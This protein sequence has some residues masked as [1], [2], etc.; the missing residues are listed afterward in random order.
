MTALRLNL[1][2]G[3]YVMGRLA[4][5][6]VLQNPAPFASVAGFTFSEPTMGEVVDLMPR[7]RLRDYESFW[8]DMMCGKP[9]ALTRVRNLIALDDA[10]RTFC[11]AK[12]R[13][14][15]AAREAEQE[16]GA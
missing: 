9:G 13:E 3:K 2:S 12:Y 5:Y 4:T 16:D 6:R 7:I 14:T 8:D 1:K 15:I 10:F 11:E